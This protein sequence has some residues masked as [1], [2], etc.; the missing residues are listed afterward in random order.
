MLKEA[1]PGP[2]TSEKRNCS[3]CPWILGGHVWMVLWLYLVIGQSI[4]SQAMKSKLLAQV[5]RKLLLEPLNSPYRTYHNI[6]YSNKQMKLVKWVFT[7]LLAMPHVRDH[8]C[9][10]NSQI[11]QISKKVS[12]HNRIQY[13]ATTKK[14]TNQWLL[15]SFTWRCTDGLKHF[16][17]NLP[18]LCLLASVHC[19]GR[20]SHRRLTDWLQSTEI[21]NNDRLQ[22]WRRQCPA[23]C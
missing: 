7:G 11:D 5:A 15:A 1:H 2:G 22:R 9:F 14:H 8:I 6:Q 10:S 23:C 19:L 20:I 16:Q 21:P 13:H 17:C 3:F 12:S 4:L 18:L